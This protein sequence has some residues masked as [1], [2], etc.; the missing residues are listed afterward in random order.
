M[1]AQRRAVFEPLEGISQETLWLRPEP[2]EW[3]I[4]ENLDHTRVLN[5]STL[6]LLKVVWVVLLP[7]A[8]LRKDQIYDVDYE[9]VYLRPDFPMNV[10]WLWPPRHT[11]ARPVSLDRLQKELCEVHGRI[12]RFYHSRD[13]ALLGNLPLWDPAIGSLNMIQAL[14]V[15]LY[16]DQLHYD[17]IRSL[18]QNGA[19][20]PG[21][22]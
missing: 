3:S 20:S 21:W 16:H 15:G 18:L 19:N 10:G 1:H 9:N 11:A 8:L 17:H 22:D 2:D 13:P 5:S 7:V 14:R 6:V 12:E 4:G